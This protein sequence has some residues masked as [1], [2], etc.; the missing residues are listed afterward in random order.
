MDRLK[1]VHVEVV[2]AKGHLSPKEVEELNPGSRVLFFDRSPGEPATMCAD[3]RFVSFVEVSGKDDRLFFQ[4]SDGEWGPRELPRRMG[5]EGIFERLPVELRVW[6]GTV[7]ASA[8][9]LLGPGAV[10]VA[11]KATE[12]HVTVELSVFGRTVATGI[13][14]I[15]GEFWGIEVHDAVLKAWDQGGSSG[16]LSVPDSVKAY[17]FSRPDRFTKEQVDAMEA[18][19]TDLVGGLRGFLPKQEVVSIDIVDQLA[20]H[21][22]RDFT[23]DTVSFFELSI[24]QRAVYDHARGDDESLIYFLNLDSETS[25]TTLADRYKERSRRIASSLPLE[26]ILVAWSG[27]VEGFPIDVFSSLLERAWSRLYPV[28]FTHR[29]DWNEQAPDQFLES[30]EMILAVRMKVDGE[31]LTIVYPY[32]YLYKLLGLLVGLR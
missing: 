17:D 27:P 31:I 32:K 13:A 9:G 29:S 12:P 14:I 20:W 5:N 26:K 6:S 16:A 22:L 3:G 25:D 24:G 18:F 30:F 23:G 28:R 10:M 8:I 7:D 15:S 2:L 11:A 19:H 1:A 21:E 4:L